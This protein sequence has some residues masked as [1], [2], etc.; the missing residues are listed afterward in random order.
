MY[1]V[2]TENLPF[3]FDNVE[4]K[5]DVPDKMNQTILHKICGQGNNAGL[6]NLNRLVQYLQASGD[7]ECLDRCCCQDHNGWNILH[8]CVREK[9]TAGFELLLRYISDE[10]WIMMRE[11]KT[12]GGLTLKEIAGTDSISQEMLQKLNVVFSRPIHEWLYH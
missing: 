11:E 7:L 2:A 5:L 9:F 8:L 6:D 10:K 12:S 1:L 3:D 4:V